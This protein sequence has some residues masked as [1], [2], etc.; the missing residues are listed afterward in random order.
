MGA[1]TLPL[2][3][4][5]R[6][7]VPDGLAH[8]ESTT[9]IPP[10]RH[11]VGRKVLGP[12]P[13]WKPSVLP[14]L[15]VAYMADL[16]VRSEAAVIA[17]IVAEIV[18]AAALLPPVPGAYNP[19]VKPATIRTT[20]CV[21][22]WS[23]TVRPPTSYTTPLKRELLARYHLPGTISG[24]QLDHLVSLAIGGAPRSRLN[25]W[26]QPLAVARR[27]DVLEARWH[28]AICSG[29]M[30]LR[31]AQRVEIRWKRVHG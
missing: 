11:V 9:R 10:L 27:D 2:A 26:M 17:A 23:S 8:L 15:D 16:R 30:T 7:R 6:P 25:L 3:Q 22:G 18:A 28:R 24:Y 21:S 1:A 12:R 20:I 19:V 29:S 14:A 31:G 4:S 13:R 5:P